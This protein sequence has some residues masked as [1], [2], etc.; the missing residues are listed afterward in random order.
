MA[1]YIQKIQSI[2]T[3]D[4][5]GNPG[6]S[7]RNSI[8][9]KL[10]IKGTSARKGMHI[11][12]VVYREYASFQKPQSKPPQ[13]I[14]QSQLRELGLSFKKVEETLLV[15][16]WKQTNNSDMA[17]FGE[18][19]ILKKAGALSYNN[20]CQ[21][22]TNRR[23][24]LEHTWAYYKIVFNIFFGELGKAAELMQAKSMQFGKDYQSLLQ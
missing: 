9:E 4:S 1:I 12:E 20:W 2:W 8:P 3:K 18:D 17:A 22:K 7:L 14:N 15:G 23:Y 19:C 11:E 10:P 13:K 24:P 16:F 6:A 5:R 21:L